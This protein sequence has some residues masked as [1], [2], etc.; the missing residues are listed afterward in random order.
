MP[1]EAPVIRYDGRC[2]FCKLWVDYWK[3]LTGDAVRYEPGEGLTAVELFLPDGEVVSG[4]RA[5]FTLMKFVPGRGWMERAYYGMPGLATASEA[6]YRMVAAHRNA[7]YRGTVLLFGRRPAPARYERTA[8]LFQKLLALIYIVAFASFAVQARGLIGSRG[9]LPIG[10]YLSA[11]HATFG[12]AALWIA[13]TVWWVSS[14]DPA[15]IAVPLLGIVAA[16]L[17]LAGAVP[18]IA[19]SAAFVLYLSICTGGQAFYS[20]QWDLLLLAAGFLAVFLGSTATIWLYRWLLFRLMFSSGVV[21][22]TSGDP[23]WRNLT[24]MS[25]HYHTQPLPSPLAWYADKLPLAFQKASTAMVFAIELLIPFL[26]FLPRRARHAGAVGIIGLQLLIVL[27]GNYAFFNILTIALC[28]FLFDDADLSRLRV[29]LRRTSMPPPRVM[30]AVTVVVLVLSAIQLSGSLLG[31]LPGPAASILRVAQP[32]GIV[33][34]YGLFAVMTTTR[35][36]IIVQGSDDG[37]N[38]RDYEFR[39]KP[40]RLTRAPM[41]VAPYQ[42]RLD[43]QMWFAALGSYQSNPWFVNFMVRLLQG[44]PEVTALLA[45]TPPGKAPRYVRAE[46]FEYSFSDAGIRARTG[47]WWV[48]QPRGLYLPAIGLED[49]RE[50]SRSDDEEPALH[51]LAFDPVPDHARAPDGGGMPEGYG[52]PGMQAAAGVAGA[53]AVSADV[54]QLAGDFHFQRIRNVQSNDAAGW[55]PGFRPPFLGAH[56]TF[57]MHSFAHPP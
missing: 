14:T 37:Q 27:T 9:I 54:E 45:G 38:W 19:L 57:R 10:R 31:Y 23:T 49:V 26:F 32:F 21:K 15:V 55:Q 56:D 4:A 34:S 1:A 2:G 33:N 39:Y 6:A 5:V 46:L 35:P 48:R 47:D 22:L 42:P 41:W 52:L 29:R 53:K 3:Q 43:W 18:R 51:L 44:S 28:L 12:T 36:E 17:A 13:P 20:F 25:Y 24:A 30:V 11:L 40:G 7:A 50:T 8:W 16:C